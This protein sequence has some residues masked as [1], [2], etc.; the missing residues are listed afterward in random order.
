MNELKEYSQAVCHDGSSSSSLREGAREREK[1]RRCIVCDEP[2]YN[3]LI[4][5]SL[6]GVSIGKSIRGDTTF[7]N[8]ISIFACW[9]Y[10]VDFALKV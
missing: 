5:S 7:D 9:M 6:W 4:M 10:C 8:I 1:E 3:Q 2:A